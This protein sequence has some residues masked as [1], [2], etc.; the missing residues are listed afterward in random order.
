MAATDVKIDDKVNV[1][2]RE[3]SKYNVIFMNDDKTTFEFVIHI[4]ETI[5]SHS[6]DNAIE[7]TNRIH[8]Q[9]KAVVGTYG[10][11]VAE[12]KCHEAISLSRSNGYPLQVKVEA[13]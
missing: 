11:E 6:R 3:P 4:L 8:E 1:V 13:V 5:F 9:E 2:L 7:L 10:F 12:Q